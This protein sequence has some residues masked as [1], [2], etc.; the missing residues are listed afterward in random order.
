MSTPI[1]REDI[2][3]GDLIKVSYTSHGVTTDR[4]GVVA[5][6]SDDHLSTAEDAY[7]WSAY[8]KG[9]FTFYLIERP[10]PPFPTTTGSIIIADFGTLGTDQII[11]HERGRWEYL[12]GGPANLNRLKS[13]KLAKVVEV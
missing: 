9:E 2:L 7:L 5:L 11:L 4:T 3:F 13:W 10:K 6:D 1:A 12:S 8:W